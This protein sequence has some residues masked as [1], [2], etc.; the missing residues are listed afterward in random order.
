M[1]KI[2]LLLALPGL[3]LLDSVAA[4][5]QCNFKGQ[6]IDG[7]YNPDCGLLI[8]SYDTWQVLVPIGNDMDIEAGQVIS[9]SYEL[10]PQP[11]PCTAGIPVELTCVEVLSSPATECNSGFSFAI[12]PSAEPEVTFAP[13]LLD[14]SLTYHWEFGDGGVADELTP[15]HIYQSGNY[16]V[17]LTVSG[18]ACEP[19]TTCKTLDLSGS[20]YCGFIVSYEQQDS[21]SVLAE[22]FNVTDFGPYHPDQVEWTNPVT[23]EVVGTE[24]VI[25]Y[26]LTGSSSSLCVA[27]SVTLPDGSTCEKV[28][29]QPFIPAP[30]GCLNWEEM[31]LSIPCPA[32]YY[33][34]CGCDGVTYNNECEAKYFGG[35][36]SWTQGPCP[37][38]QNP[39]LASFYSVLEGG[40]L[41]LF[42][43]SVGAFTD[44]EWDLGGGNIVSNQNIVSLPSVN[45]G[46][47]SICLTVSNDN[48]CTSQ[49]CD[50]IYN[51]SVEELC[52]LTD[53]VYPGDADVDGTANVYD[54]LN[55]G[56]GYGAQGPPRDM[57]AANIEWEPQFAPDW[58]VNT[59][60]EVDYKHLDCNGDGVV[61]DFDIEAI[62]A[63]YSAPSNIFSVQAAGAPMFWLDFEWDTIV[64]D[65]NSPEFIEINASLMAGTPQYPVTD[66]RGFALQLDYPED[67]VMEQG[68]AEVD[69]HD[70]S[71]LGS[72]NQILWLAKDRYNDNGRLDLGFTKKINHTDGFG[73]IAD[74]KFIVISDVI[75]RSESAAPFSIGIGDVVAVNE[76]GEMLAIGL[77]DEDA[78]VIIV[79]QMTTPTH[80]NPLDRFVSVF[81]NPTTSKVFIRLRRIKAES[82]GV[83]NSVGRKIEERTFTG[84]NLELD[85]T[86]WSPGV[87]WL[88]IQTEEGLVV[89]RVMV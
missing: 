22:V 15:S 54:L 55:L 89:K 64:V 47:Y 35:V 75:G 65:D 61:N 80:E 67:M 66:L 77:P 37:G 58:E 71:I 16:S 56:V 52:N 28:I 40:T 43:T 49:F 32:Y 27:F 70:N 24:P 4:G 13:D 69:Y 12:N 60:S 81:P 38:A 87:Y 33:P 25:T 19:A 17:C 20:D 53:C 30:P 68:G 1:K 74:V 3:L 26:P 14:N 83:Y 78:T 63:N 42:N 9:F 48:G 79:N 57:A 39:C 36:T 50:Y 88:K 86:A 51:G 21:T 45:E 73:K 34:V 72:S 85:A 44:I 8:L 7:S 23:G 41:T 82:A 84:S 76:D 6:V 29:C 2:L 18:A 59:I 31:N 10:S 62:E 11:S 5:A 46:I